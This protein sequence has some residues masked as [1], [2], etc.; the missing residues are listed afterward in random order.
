MSPSIQIKNLWFPI[1]I[2][3]HSQ[4]FDTMKIVHCIHYVIGKNLVA[5]P[6]NN[7][8]HKYSIS[9]YRRVS[10]IGESY[11]IRTFNFAFTQKIRGISYIPDVGLG[12]EMRIQINGL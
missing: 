6:I 8:N 3:S 11:L 4:H 2:H 9:S 7:S 1:G 5:E 10:D 12:Y